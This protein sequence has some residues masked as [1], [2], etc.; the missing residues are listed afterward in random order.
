MRSPASSFGLVDESCATCDLEEDIVGSRWGSCGV[1]RQ[2]SCVRLIGRLCVV[3]HGINRGAISVAAPLRLSR[4]AT[5]MAYESHPTGRLCWLVGAMS[6]VPGS[7]CWIDV[8]ST[9]PAG[10]RDFYA[11]LL[12]WTYRI[13]LTEAVGV[14]PPRCV[15][16]GRW[17]ASR[18]LRCRQGNLWS[19]R[20]I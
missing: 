14:T 17:L 20:C 2:V 4:H 10:S 12:G 1:G 16:A 7:V 6:F 15:A 5:R 19:G 11:G 13:D 8:S 9:N 18:A 3:P